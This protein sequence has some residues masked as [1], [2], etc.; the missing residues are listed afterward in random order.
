[1]SIGH[2]VLGAL[3]GVEYLFSQIGKIFEEPSFDPDSAE[4]NTVEPADE[5]EDP[6]EGFVD[7]EDSTVPLLS[8]SAPTA[9]K[10]S[11][12]AELLM[13]PSVSRQQPPLRTPHIVLPRHRQHLPRPGTSSRESPPPPPSSSVQQEPPCAGPAEDPE[14]R[15]VLTGTTT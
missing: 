8:P 9:S 13:R 2:C 1:M 7:V 5:E 4:A 12:A 15:I 11:T 6:D 10:P 14:V 3:I